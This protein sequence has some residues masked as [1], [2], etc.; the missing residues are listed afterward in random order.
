MLEGGVTVLKFD[1]FTLEKTPID[2]R[3]GQGDPL[4]MIFYQYYNADLLDIPE[5]EGEEAVAY[6]GG[7]FMLATG[8]HFHDAHRKPEDMMCKEKGVNWSKT[9]SSPLEYSQLALID[10]VHRQ[11]K[12]ESPALQLP[13]KT[14]EPSESTKYLGVVVD[15][16]LT[17]KAQQSYAVEKATKR[18]PGREKHLPV[19]G[20]CRS[21]VLCRRH[22]PFLSRISRPYHTLGCPC[23][24]MSGGGHS[25]HRRYGSQPIRFT[26]GLVR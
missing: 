2:N 6:V 9:H 10:F 3:I 26:G 24:R 13:H 5:H 17:W 12:A 21:E 23:C 15:R 4:S 19:C 14:I 25:L 8:H 11:S 16:N 22:A 20:R 18:W 7:A 1:G